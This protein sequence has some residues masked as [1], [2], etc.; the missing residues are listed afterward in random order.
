MVHLSLYH[1]QLCF[2]IDRIRSISG[3]WGY[4]NVYLFYLFYLFIPGHK[5]RWHLMSWRSHVKLLLGLK[6][7]VN[8]GC[9][10]NELFSQWLIRQHLRSIH[11]RPKSLRQCLT[12][13]FANVRYPVLAIKKLLIDVWNAIL[14]LGS[15]NFRSL[16]V[17]LDWLWINLHVFDRFTS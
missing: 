11:H 15:R 5:Y 8:C 1:L 10:A 6:D 4:I 17:S 9:F 2:S 7:T 3:K 13:Q 12:G 16:P 14:I